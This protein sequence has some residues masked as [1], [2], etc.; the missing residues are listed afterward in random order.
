MDI[1]LK[2]ILNWDISNWSQALNFWE[3]EITHITK[4][5]QKLE[6]ALE[7]GGREGGLSL[8]L[9]QFCNKVVCSDL[10]NTEKTAKVLH[11]KYQIN[12]ISYQ[13]ISALEIPYQDHFDIIIF[14]SIIGGIAQGDNKDVQQKVFDQILN[15]LKPGGMLLFAENLQSTKV[16][17]F[18]RRKM[19]KWGDYWRYV[20][21][22]E[23]KEFTSNFNKTTIQSNGM[24][25][26][27]GRNENQKNK[28]GK[29]DKSLIDKI[30]PSS[31]KYIGYGVAVK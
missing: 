6:I 1:P 16:H 25:G 22:A 31:W 8:W 18:M 24:L 3:T 9:S 28:L 5:E 13:N 27:F 7:L 15:A 19:N 10:E 21:L 30:T 23:L 17:S 2:D 4:S 26:A 20:T 29:I 14:K 11:D 12:N